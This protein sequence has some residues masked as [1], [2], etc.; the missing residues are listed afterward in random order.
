M[1]RHRSPAAPLSRHV[2]HGAP[3]GGRCLARHQD[4]LRHHAAASVVRCGGHRCARLPAHDQGHED[5]DD[6]AASCE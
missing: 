4:A 2:G 6:D 5:H 3:L 1:D